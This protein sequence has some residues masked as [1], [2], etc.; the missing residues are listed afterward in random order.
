MKQATGYSA[1]QIG[2]HRIAAV[3]VAAKYLLKGRISSAWDADA[4]GRDIA[5]SPRSFPMPRAAC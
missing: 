2:L 4:A 1:T 3:L 5:F